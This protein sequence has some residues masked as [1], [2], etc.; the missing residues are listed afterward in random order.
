MSSIRGVSEVGSERVV[1]GWI[2]VI[3]E[4]IRVVLRSQEEA[5]VSNQD[6]WELQV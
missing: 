3:R 1:E 4:Y 6:W 5:R 2:G